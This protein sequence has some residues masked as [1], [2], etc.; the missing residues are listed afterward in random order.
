M[1]PVFGLDGRLYEVPKLWEL[2]A[3]LP[4]FRMPVAQLRFKLDH[5]T[6][7]DEFGLDLTPNT[8][9]ANPDAHAEHWNCISSADLSFPILIFTHA[10]NTEVV[11]GMHRLARALVEKRETID[12]RIPSRDIMERAIFVPKKKES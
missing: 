2:T 5:F 7:N 10:T 6:W 11:D 4:I 1:I 12:V 8:V 3:D 9:L